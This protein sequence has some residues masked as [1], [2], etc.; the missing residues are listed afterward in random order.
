MIPP[1]HSKTEELLSSRK[2]SEADPTEGQFERDEEE[3]NLDQELVDNK[4]PVKQEKQTTV[5]TNTLSHE[6]YSFFYENSVWEQYED[7]VYAI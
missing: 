4:V 7:L 1:K 6:D 5:M 3:L 2:P